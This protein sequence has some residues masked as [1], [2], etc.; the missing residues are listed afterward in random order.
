MELYKKLQINK[1]VQI[2]KYPSKLKFKNLKN[3]NNFLQNKTSNDIIDISN[4]T[5]LNEPLEEKKINKIKKVNFQ[6][7]N[8]YISSINK[9]YN[10]TDRSINI[11]RHKQQKLNNGRKTNY[12]FQNKINPI[13]T[14]ISNSFQINELNSNSMNPNKDIINNKSANY[15][16][17][18]I[19]N[20]KILLDNINCHG[21][22]TNNALNKSNDIISLNKI[23]NSTNKTNNIRSHSGEHKND[24]YDKKFLSLIKNIRTSIDKNQN[25][26]NIK[27]FKTIN[28]GLTNISKT[29]HKYIQLNKQ[30]RNKSNKFKDKINSNKKNILED[31]DIE[32]SY[33][34]KNNSYL[35]YT[36]RDKKSKISNIKDKKE[37]YLLKYKNNTLNNKNSEDKKKL[38]I[39][40]KLNIKNEKN[41][42]REPEKSS[43]LKKYFLNYKSLKAI[44][45]N[46]N[47]K[48]NIS[49]NKKNKNEKLFEQHLSLNKVNNFKYDFLLSNRNKIIDSEN[50]IILNNNN[51]NIDSKNKNIPLVYKKRIALSPFLTNKKIPKVF[52]GNNETNNNDKKINNSNFYSSILT[53]K[54]KPKIK[55]N[56]P[57]INLQ[58]KYNYIKL[59]NNTL[60]TKHEINQSKS[61]Y[62][63]NIDPKIYKDLIEEIK[64]K[65][66][67]ENP[68]KIINN[69][70]IS[71]SD[72]NFLNNDRLCVEI[73]K[74]SSICKG[75]ENYPY[76]E[77]KINQ[78][79]LFKTKFDDLNISFYGICDGHGE[80]GHLISEFIEANLPLIMYKEIKSLFYLLN[81]KENKT[82]E[83][84]KAY[85]SEICKQSFDIA[86]KKLISNKNIDSSLSGCTCISLL[87]YE[88]LIISAN[89]GDSRAIMGKLIDNKWNY[90]LLSRDHKP[91][92]ID[93]ILRIKYK[94]GEIHP[95]INEDGRFSGQNRVWVKGQGIPGLSLT[96]AFGDIIGSTVGILS[97]PEIKFFNYEKEDKFIIIGSDGLW[98]YISC[99]EAVNIVAEFYHIDKLDSDNAVIKLF[100]IARNR[101]I[102]T[103]NCIDDISIIILFL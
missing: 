97:E 67:E 101:W 8:F 68:K 36:Y 78:D 66:E 88:N 89:L 69:N 29:S 18:N 61:C 33:D 102:E 77:K 57:K 90:E 28:K 32:N 83:Q 65:K 100:Q 50:S 20:Y 6:P 94:N 52:S 55:L 37:K 47:N 41:I 71:F 27:I 12:Y 4:Y 87:F 44:N 45:K 56:K 5:L 17:K 2:N 3:N 26:K 42:N 73:K 70:Q 91:S 39:S 23:F 95:Y 40:L 15:I 16:K 80:N 24:F 13:Y 96:R 31:L 81:N 34:I 62:Q 99:Q 75:G 58:K 43:K 85:F 19:L 79:N 10:N 48:N 60:N 38:K 93:E 49:T 64:L 25:L 54:T 11:N 7:V 72:I 92:E 35:P 76:E 22:K 98:E 86:N 46:K 14:N 21:F 9:V 53:Q 74:N 30:F 51:Y 82:Q 103:Q 59:N 1:K 84:I 63:I